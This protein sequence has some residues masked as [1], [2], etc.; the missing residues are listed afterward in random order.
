M[1]TKMANA[2]VRMFMSPKFRWT[3]CGLCPVWL[4]PETHPEVI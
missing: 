1:K 4:V 3:A 2:I